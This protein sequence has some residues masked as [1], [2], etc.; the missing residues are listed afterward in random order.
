MTQRGDTKAMNL[1]TPKIQDTR[2]MWYCSHPYCFFTV[3]GH[4]RDILEHYADQHKC[5]RCNAKK[6]RKC[7]KDIC[8]CGCRWGDP[9]NK[10]ISIA[11]LDKIMKMAFQRAKHSGNGL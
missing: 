4:R 6:H 2:Q 5:G 7:R 9:E 8:G 3:V 11:H 1:D 10:T